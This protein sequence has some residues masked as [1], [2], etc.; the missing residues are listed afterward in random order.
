MVTGQIIIKFN[1]DADTE[2]ELS[3]SIPARKFNALS[4]KL[5]RAMRRHRAITYKANEA[6]QI[7][8]R[9][10]ELLERETET[11][12]IRAEAEAKAALDNIPGP[13]PAFE[14]NF[15]KAEPLENLDDDLVIDT[16]PELEPEEAKETNESEDTIDDEERN[17]G[18]VEG[19][20]S[21]GSP[22]N[23][24]EHQW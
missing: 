8:E 21:S 10:Q 16:E 18:D 13:D 1:D 4:V 24:K 23:E 5:Q 22:E 11:A 2:I 12:R 7:E 14:K 19:P 20:G 9:R 3:G 6:A 15:A 17:A